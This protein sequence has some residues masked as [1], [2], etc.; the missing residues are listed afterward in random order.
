MSLLKLRLGFFVTD[1]F[2]AFWN[3]SGGPCATFF[4]SWIKGNS[5]AYKDIETILACTPKRR[6]QKF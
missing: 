4:C 6:G 3:I 1:F 2:P 5:S